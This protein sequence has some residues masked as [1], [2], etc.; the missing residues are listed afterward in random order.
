MRIVIIG[1]GPTGLTLG[2]A[3]AGR[4]HDVVSVD[5]DRGPAADGS[6]RR[7]GVMQFE[8]A[9]GFRPQVRDLLLAEWP[10]AYD[11][12]VGLGAEAIEFEMPGPGPAPVIVRSRRSTY[13][14]SLRAAA[15]RVRGLTVRVGHVDRL[16]VRRGR[17]VGVE[18]DGVPVDAD[19]VVDASGRADR[20]APTTSGDL[21]GDCGMA[22]VNRV[23]RRHRGAELGPLTNPIAWGG[24]FDGYQAIVFPHDHRYLSVVLIRPT[25]DE[26]LRMLRYT[27][28]F[29][30]AC[31]VIPGLAAWTDPTRSAPA[32]DVLVG[33]RLRNVYRPQRRVPGLVSVGDSV[34]TT[35]PT[36]GRGVA[37]CSLQIRALL[38]L[39]DDGAD[40]ISAAVP[41]GD[42]CDAE[43]RPW[44]EDHI[45]TDH[46]AVRRWQS[47]DIDLASPLTSAA[48]VDAGQADARILEH[49]G[50]FLAMT[51]PPSSLAEAEPL[52][53]TV[54]ESGW[55]PPYTDGPTRDELVAV[56]ESARLPLAG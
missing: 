3:L 17:V 43:I 28:A 22:Y 50:G 54:Y 51:A 2:A 38:D 55:R 10:D 36:A 32:G 14:R 52:A 33:G 9:H 41:F 26:A 42:W 4:G 39:L 30:A 15:V 53:R 25:A 47:S 48:I 49:I 11:E 45:V 12:W 40:P 46:E 44:V 16:V 20:V 23:Y 13:E 5:R 37:L 7:R 34:A 21:G 24:T 1:A 31:Q 29:D 8:H 56:I 18:V 27:D 35:T 19:L 6:W